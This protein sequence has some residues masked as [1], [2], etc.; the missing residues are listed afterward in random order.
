MTGELD[1]IGLRQP[2]IIRDIAQENIVPFGR[3][4]TFR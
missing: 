4:R 3:R 1:A 2:A